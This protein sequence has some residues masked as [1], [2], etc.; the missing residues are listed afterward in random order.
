VVVELFQER[1]ERLFKYGQEQNKSKA[2]EKVK[3]QNPE[4]SIIHT[5]K[6]TASW[7]RGSKKPANT[8]PTS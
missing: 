2:K 5:Q 8:F 6:Q 7:P 4:H 1:L 3:E